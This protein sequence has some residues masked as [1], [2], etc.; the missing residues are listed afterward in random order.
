MST[1]ATRRELIWES[2]KVGALFSVA[3][4][5]HHVHSRLFT[6][7]LFTL[8]EDTHRQH[9]VSGPSLFNLL[10]FPLVLVPFL[11]TTLLN[12]VCCSTSRCLFDP[13]R[14]T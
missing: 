1:I 14:I 4:F 13:G 7:L 10:Q 12:A 11:L 5:S 2:Q 9:S 3:L 6:R 8:G